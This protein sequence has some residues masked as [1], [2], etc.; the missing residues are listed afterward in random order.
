PACGPGGRADRADGGREVL[1]RGAIGPPDPPSPPERRDPD[2]DPPARQVAVADAD[3]AR[4]ERRRID[5]GCAQ[6]VAEPLRQVDGEPALVWEVVAHL[7]LLPR[8]CQIHELHGRE[9]P[10]D[11]GT[12][13]RAL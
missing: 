4:R 5:P 2:L 12:K 1:I 11:R 9:R 8:P 6:T 7:A 10:A 3:V 13:C